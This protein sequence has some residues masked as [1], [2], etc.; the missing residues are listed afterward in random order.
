MATM[1]GGVNTTQPLKKKV[2][3]YH[4]LLYIVTTPRKYSLKCILLH[5]NVVE[6]YICDRHRQGPSVTGATLSLG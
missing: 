3:V 5:R 4:K 1:P 6:M 2:I